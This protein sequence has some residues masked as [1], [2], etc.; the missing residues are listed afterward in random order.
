MYLSYFGPIDYAL[1]VAN[2]FLFIKT[3]DVN[4]V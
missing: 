4:L 3:L 2:H 1:V